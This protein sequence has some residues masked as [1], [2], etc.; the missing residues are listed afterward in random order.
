MWEYE[1]CTRKNLEAE[2]VGL[3]LGCAVI[4]HEQKGDLCAL[5]SEFEPCTTAGNPL[6]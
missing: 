5:M 3:K 1:A 4:G 6:Y 2:G